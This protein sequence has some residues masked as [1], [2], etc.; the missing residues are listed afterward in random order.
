LH[1][2]YFQQVRFFW[3][4]GLRDIVLWKAGQGLAVDNGAKP[5]L[6]GEP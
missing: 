4:S 1:C 6:W 2:P 5:G 3:S